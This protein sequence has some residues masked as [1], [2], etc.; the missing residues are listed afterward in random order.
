MHASPSGIGFALIPV[1]KLLL[2]NLF[3][4]PLWRSL[5][6]EAAEARLPLQGEKNPTPI[7]TDSTPVDNQNQQ[8]TNANNDTQLQIANNDVHD[9]QTIP[10]P[11]LII[12]QKEPQLN[13]SV[14]VPVMEMENPTT[15]DTKVDDHQEHSL[16]KWP[17]GRGWFTQVYL[18]NNV[19]SFFCNVGKIRIVSGC[20]A[21]QSYVSFLLFCYFR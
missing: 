20:F 2:A 8:Q 19:L 17:K 15:E 6:P 7:T 21:L 1:Y 9:Q 13:G 11:T 18:Q 14:K 10:P 5:L 3:A 12:Q 16:W 4:C